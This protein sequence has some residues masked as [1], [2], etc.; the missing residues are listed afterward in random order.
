MSLSGGFKKIAAYSVLVGFAALMPVVLL[1]WFGAASQASETAKPGR[2]SSAVFG[3]ATREA[4]R[5]PHG[6]AKHRTLECSKC[7]MITAG[8]IDEDRFPGHAACITCHNF[9]VEALARPSTFCGICHDGRAISKNQPALFRYPKPVVGSDFG[10]EFSHVSHEKP[11]AQPAIVVRLPL[12]EVQVGGMRQPLCIDCHNGPGAG[13]APSSRMTQAQSSVQPEISTATGHPSC[14]ACHG[15]KPVALPSLNQCNACHKLDAPR[16]PRLYGI[17]R[18]FKHPDHV[19]DT[20]PVL[21]VDAAIPRAPDYLC[22][23]CHDSATKAARL[24]Q[25]RLPGTSYCNDC[26]NGN[27]GLPDP[28]EQRVLDSLKRPR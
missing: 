5:F 12:Q 4:A 8:K 24:D 23:Q 3:Q 26:H 17:V 6:K 7:H 20:R 9:A 11:E 14:F 27:L 1:G 13:L 22:S 18:D 25:I 16:Y 19:Y 2:P 15:E 21:K 10:I 28:L